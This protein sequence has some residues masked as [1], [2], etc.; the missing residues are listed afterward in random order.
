[1]LDALAQASEG[2]WALLIGRKGGIAG[3]ELDALQKLPFVTVVGLGSR[4]L[5][6]DTAALAALACWQAL[7]GEWRRPRAC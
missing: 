6:A 4:V 3:S 5:R 1:M 7:V 2:P